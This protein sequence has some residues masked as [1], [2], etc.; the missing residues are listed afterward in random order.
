MKHDLLELLI[1]V[2]DS[3]WDTRIPRCGAL[4]R[5]AVQSNLIRRTGTLLQLT[6]LGGAKL[7]ESG[8]KTDRSRVIR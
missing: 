4:I 3:D 5:E 1:A 6:A 7:R 2:H 8:L